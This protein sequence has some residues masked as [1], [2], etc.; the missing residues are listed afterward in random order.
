MV[1][2]FAINHVSMNALSSI[3]AFVT[4]EG[5]YSKGQKDASYFLNQY[6]TSRS[7]QDYQRFLDAISIPLADHDARIALQQSPPNVKL[8]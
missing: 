4:A 3:R 8:A 1:L 5:F 2:L 7:Q 6:A